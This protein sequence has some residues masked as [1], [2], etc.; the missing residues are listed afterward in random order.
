MNLNTTNRKNIKK[1][2]SSLCLSTF[3]P[4]TLTTVT[5]VKSY[6]HNEPEK[7]EGVKKSS[8]LRFAVNKD[9][10][11]INPDTEPNN[12][13]LK[14]DTVVGNKEPMVTTQS[15]DTIIEVENINK[16]DLS[17]TVKIRRGN[18][19][20]KIVSVNDGKFVF[21]NKIDD[22]NPILFLKINQRYQFQITPELYKK[23]PIRILDGSGNVINSVLNDP[24]VD[25]QD[26]N[27]SVIIDSETYN[28]PY[29][30]ECGIHFTKMSGSIKVEKE[31]YTGII[32][33]YN[34]DNQLF[35][36]LSNND[37][38]VSPT[39]LDKIFNGLEKRT[40]LFQSES[41]KITFTNLK[42]DTHYILF[43]Y[44]DTPANNND[45]YI[46]SVYDVITADNSN[47]VKRFV[48]KLFI[49]PFQHQSK[50]Q[51]IHFTK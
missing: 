17:I 5:N 14:D 20:E 4:P 30:Y 28:P 51:I 40:Q 26:S 9:M 8:L 37:N 42:V 49:N 2:I 18:N 12:L 43:I 3:K 7:H 22:P 21:D 39:I 15:S 48:Y 27:I 1:D 45:T 32:M 38:D 41:N 13:Y 11:Y 31:K 19:I 6:I 33:D 25:G 50:I 29:T 36:F 47:R 46:H 35:G 24:S 34:N 23:H 44:L 16:E 10:R